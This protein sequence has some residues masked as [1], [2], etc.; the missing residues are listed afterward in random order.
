[1]T[2]NQIACGFQS[3]PEEQDGADEEEEGGE[4][5]DDGVCEFVAR[6]EASRLVVLLTGLDGGRAS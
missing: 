1:M 5:V 4:E 2:K 3:A 6:V